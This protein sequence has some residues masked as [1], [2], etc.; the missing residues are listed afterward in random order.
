MAT[1]P[2]QE[3]MTTSPQQEAMMTSPQQEAMTTSPQQ[4]ASYERE[5][6]AEAVIPVVFFTIMI[7]TSNFQAAILRN[8]YRKVLC[9]FS[10]IK[11][12]ICQTINQALC[13]KDDLF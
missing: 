6:S 7:I 5:S 13:K 12:F 3:A 2:E 9:I 11:N 4:E 8:Y 10:L 1:S